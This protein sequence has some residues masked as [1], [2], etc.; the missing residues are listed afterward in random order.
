MS[1]PKQPAPEQLQLTLLSAW[2]GREERREVYVSGVL[3]DGQYGVR[4][5]LK[6]VGRAGKITVLDFPPGVFDQLLS[7]VEDAHEFQARILRNH[8]Q[9]QQSAETSTL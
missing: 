6:R 4:I 2:Q 5:V 3:S 1:R 7:R 8:Q 9:A